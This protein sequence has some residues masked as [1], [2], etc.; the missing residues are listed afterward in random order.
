[1]KI[2]ITEVWKNGA[3]ARWRDVDK[4]L[5]VIDVPMAQG[6]HRFKIAGDAVQ[7]WIFTHRPDLHQKLASTSQ[8]GHGYH[9]EEVKDAE[10]VDTHIVP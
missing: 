3:K 8:D 10:A 7:G 6:I 4:E 1:M 9:A 2:R 5:A